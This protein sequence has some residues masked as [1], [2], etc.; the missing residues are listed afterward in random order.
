MDTHEDFT[1]KP[2]LD[3]NSDEEVVTSS[4][5]LAGMIGDTLAKRNQLLET[6]TFLDNELKRIN[7]EIRRIEEGTLVELMDQMG[8]AAL[9]DASGAKLK[10][11]QVVTASLTNV[12]VRAKALAFLR[13]HGLADLITTD[14]TV[15]FRKG[16]EDK[17]NSALTS[18][19]SV[20][21]SENVVAEENVHTASYKAAIKELMA[22]GATIPADD[23]GVFVVRKVVVKN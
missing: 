14:L 16:E 11:D 7:A 21:G 23:I 4:A 18:L 22:Q 13:A 3:D 5:P 6:R 17:A 20:Y 12:D 10:L 15:R 1:A 19:V 8:V 9:T 2:W